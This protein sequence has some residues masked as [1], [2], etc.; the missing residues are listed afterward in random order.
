MSIQKCLSR[1]FQNC[2]P[3]S[4]P[5]FLFLFK[6][7]VW[8]RGRGVAVSIFP[9]PPSLLLFL[10]PATH[11]KREKKDMGKSVGFQKRKDFP[12]EIRWF[13]VS[14][15]EHFVFRKRGKRNKENLVEEK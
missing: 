1:T 3:P 14:W 9:F 7:S 6:K 8:E 13:P 2:I 5:C 4:I 10:F 12:A 11:G 15:G